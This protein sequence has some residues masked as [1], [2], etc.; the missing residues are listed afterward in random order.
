MSNGR[1]GKNLKPDTSSETIS[2]PPENVSFGNGVLDAVKATTN[3]RSR[4][5]AEAAVNKMFDYFEEKVKDLPEKVKRLRN[6]PETQE[7]FIELWSEQ[8]YEKGM[9]PKGYKG[10]PDDLLIHSFQQDGYIEGIYV[11]ILLTLSTLIDQGASK[12][13]II[14]LR[15][16]AMPKVGYKYYEDREALIND[17]NEKIGSWLKS[18][19]GIES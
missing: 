4:I 12:Q 5:L 9:V 14:E 16:Q 11:G 13:M 1:K 18:E 2:S 6:S 8:L 10:L 3:E 7:R 15:K 17:L 19:S